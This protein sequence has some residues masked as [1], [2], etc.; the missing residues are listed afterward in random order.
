MSTSARISRIERTLRTQAREA[1]IEKVAADFDPAVARANNNE[2][3]LKLVME[4]RAA[5]I[6]SGKAIAEND[7]LEQFL[8]ERAPNP[9]PLI[10]LDALYNPVEVRIAANGERLPDTAEN[11]VAV[12]YPQFVYANGLSP[13]FSI[14]TEVLPNWQ[15]AVDAGP[16]FE[17]FG[18]DKGKW[19]LWDDVEASLTIN[20][21]TNNP[22]VHMA[23]AKHT[24]TDEI[25]WT[26]TPH[27][28]SSG[29]AVYVN[30]HLGLVN[31]NCRLY[32]GRARFVRLVPAS[33]F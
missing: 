15:A 17:L 14:H 20:R 27:P 5:V 26:R 28:S 8:A 6:R 3:A 9:K 12:L 4:A 10:S 29:G 31:W 32:R 21:R 22:A 30:L 1:F 2:A 7:A 33:Q 19:Q 16:K 23:F 25:Y 11:Y 18:D 13:L 24:P